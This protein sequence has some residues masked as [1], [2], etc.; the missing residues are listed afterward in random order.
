MAEIIAIAAPEGGGTA[1][2]PAEDL[3][4]AG[5]LNL[6]DMMG[7][8]NGDGG[9]DPN[10]TPWKSVLAEFHVYVLRSYAPIYIYIYIYIN[11]YLCTWLCTLK[12]LHTPLNLLPIDFGNSA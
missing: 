10:K 6:I 2:A 3:L 7:N 1:I 12:E 9:D 11:S 5:A 8:G 4:G